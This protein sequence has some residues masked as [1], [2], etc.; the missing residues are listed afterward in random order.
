MSENKRISILSLLQSMSDGLREYFESRNFEVLKREEVTQFEDIDFI[1]L[2]SE[3]DCHDI[4]REFSV[5]KN[6]IRLI[7]L[8]KPASY[9]NFLMQ[10]GRLV[11][12]ENFVE[13]QLG[14]SILNK[15]FQNEL[16]IHLA[17]DFS[18]VVSKT[19]E[20]SILN[21]LSGGSFIDQACFDSFENGF[22]IVSLR[23]YID[24]AIYYF[25]YLK[26]AGLGGSPFEFEY[27][28]NENNF[29]L[30]A[31]M[32]V[33]GFVAEYLI[34][35]FG[36]YEVQNPHRY[37]LNAMGNNCEFLEVTY[38]ENPSKI[39]LNAIWS[40]NPEAKIQG[41]AFQNIHTYK[42]M[43]R[44]IDE[45]ISS[46][47]QDI[48]I[49][50]RQATS[51]PM[52]ESLNLPGGIN[53]ITHKITDDSI[54]NK[55]EV[56]DSLMDF[57]LDSFDINFPDTSL[58]S[59][60]E[61]GLDNLLDAFPDQEM[62]SNLTAEDKAH[63]LE[64]LQK[65]EVMEKVS[66]G[67]DEEEGTQVVP[68][69]DELTDISQRISD[70]IDVDDVI[71]NVSGGEEDDNFSQKVSGGDEGEDKFSQKIS[72]SK[73]T[74]EVMTIIGGQD[75]ANDFKK[76]MAS[77]GSEN[78]FLITFQNKMKPSDKIKS[79]K[80]VKNLVLK[81]LGDPSLQDVDLKVK[82]YFRQNAPKKLARKMSEFAK[83]RKKEVIDL[84]TSELE[85]FRKFEAQKVFD[86]VLND[87]DAIDDFQNTLVSSLSIGTPNLS[88]IDDINLE[89]D[90]DPNYLSELI[91]KKLE[92]A[93]SN[94]QELT[95]ENKQQII[96][97]SIKDYIRDN[98]D[99]EFLSPEEKNQV[100]Q[101]ITEE[102]SA[103]FKIP[104]TDVEAIIAESTQ[105][106]EQIVSGSPEV[107][108]SQEIQNIKSN[109]NDLVKT[110]L[111]SRIKKMEEENKHLHDKIKALGIHHESQNVIK[112]KINAINEEAKAT[113]EQVAASQNSDVSIDL[114]GTLYSSE[115]QA[116]LEK[117]SRGEALNDEEKIKVQSLMANGERAMQD[118]KKEAVNQVKKSQIE[119]QNKENL[120]QAELSKLE[121]ALKSKDVVVDKIKE[122]MQNIVGKK[123]KELSALKNQNIQLT[124]T[125]QDNRSNALDV[126]L[127]QAKMDKESSERALEMYKSKL[128]VTM[129][130]LEESKRS[131]NSVLINEENRNLKRLKI[132]LEK[133][134]E[135]TEKLKLRLEKKNM[136]FMETDKKLKID[137]VKLQENA[138]KM[139]RDLKS[140]QN[141]IAT[142]VTG[143][144]AQSSAE[145]KQLQKEVEF[146]KD[147]AK[148]L[149]EKISSLRAELDKASSQMNAQSLNQSSTKLS[150]QQSA[151]KI[152]ALTSELEVSKTQIKTLQTENRKLSDEIE[153]NKAVDTKPKPNPADAGGSVMEKKL[154]QSVKLLNSELAKTKTESAELKKEAMKYKKEVTG[155]K[156][157]VAALTKDLDKAKKAATAK[158]GKKAA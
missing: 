152:Q 21:H 134:L 40:K 46:F 6:K 42:Q 141:T 102:I 119:F 65:K 53:Q 4:A 60:T 58:P 89:F 37:L 88:A 116:L 68:D 153:M 91:S 80:D 5:E 132:S 150:E 13:S 137:N 93:K 143:T 39:I 84:D 97:S 96:K 94:N 108:T 23:T 78:P 113:D 92:F 117:V 32:S 73:D 111:L 140:M 69:F 77:F 98:L 107:D 17:E 79:T 34:D 19:R 56:L 122:S 10:N 135:T 129:K 22:N 29:I 112:E 74:P 50:K 24:H 49:A 2:D 109:T 157:K 86:E 146:H 106:K 104:K 151:E 130:K 101:K 110:E 51:M 47:E 149:Q 145:K 35:A 33:R 43:S 127:K 87:A 114:P 120:Y 1:L 81:T 139:E 3:L 90:S 45:D 30:N 61:V 131:D 82:E 154:E 9:R 125:M 142:K 8:G 133:K 67:V 115:D 11:I 148:K 118:M 66:G 124:Q 63:L 25:S 20:F 71:N 126:Q 99:L 105:K 52:V 75:S 144:N 158:D 123:D 41:M 121:R 27:G 18:E 14:L 28:M 62:I 103:K 76:Q 155:L 26:Q 72:G 54:L 12:E 95:P 85:E 70:L 44:K 38:L 36:E 83:K 15:F 156:N 128:D 48:D 31:H 16:S 7:C 136:E 59:L 64:K 55:E 57:S 100:K 147:Q 138:K